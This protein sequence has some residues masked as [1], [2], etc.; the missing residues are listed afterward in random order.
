MQSMAAHVL[1]N[2]ISNLNCCPPYALAPHK[3][4]HKLDL[5][6]LSLEVSSKLPQV[7]VGPCL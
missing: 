4:G 7:S 2:F 5:S 6:V 1:T 3:Y